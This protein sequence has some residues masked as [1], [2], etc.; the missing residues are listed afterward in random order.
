MKTFTEYRAFFKFCLDSG[1]ILTPTDRQQLYDSNYNY[2]T[3]KKGKNE[4]LISTTYCG[5]KSLLEYSDETK[6]TA[7]AL[8][9]PMRKQSPILL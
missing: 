2:V 9:G 7:F 4:L 8:V 6:K 3:C 5:L 1:I